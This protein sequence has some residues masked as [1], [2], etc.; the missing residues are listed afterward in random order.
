MISNT[1]LTQTLQDLLDKVGANTEESV[2]IW[3]TFALE[4]P[5]LTKSSPQE[6]WISVVKSLSHIM[7][8]K[9]KTYVVGFFNGDLKVFDKHDNKEVISVR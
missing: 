4:K 3:Y 9:A 5:K 8:E 7:N 6:E 1:F 2:E